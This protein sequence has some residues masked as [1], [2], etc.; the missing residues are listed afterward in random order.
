MPIPVIFWKKHQ[1]ECSVWCSR[2]LGIRLIIPLHFQSATAAMAG[3]HRQM[4]GSLAEI[5]VTPPPVVSGSVRWERG[6]LPTLTGSY[7][8]PTETVSGR[9]AERRLN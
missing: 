9:R 4:M 3:R 5:A 7:Y 6:F 1:F 2:M 8:T